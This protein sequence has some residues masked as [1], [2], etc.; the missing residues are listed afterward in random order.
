MTRRD[1]I[2]TKLE[3]KKANIKQ[4]MTAKMGSAKTKKEVKK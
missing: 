4:K 2:R 3:A 1:K